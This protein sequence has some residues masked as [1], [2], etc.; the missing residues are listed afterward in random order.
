M[1]GNG[2]AG[3]GRL[4]RDQ[5][6]VVLEVLLAQVV[7]IRRAELLPFDQPDPVLLELGQDVREGAQLA[8]VQLAD[9]LQALIDLLLGRAPVHGQ[10]VDAGPDLLL[11][12]ADAFHEELVEVRAHDRDELE[13]LEQ[14]CARILGHVQHAEREVQPGELTVEV[15]LGPL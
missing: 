4:G 5:R 2:W 11:Q 7:S 10:I 9:E 8:L 3:V 1:N 12:A 6:V 14:W 15:V 13:A